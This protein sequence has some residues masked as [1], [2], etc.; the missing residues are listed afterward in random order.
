MAA[1]ESRKARSILRSI[2]SVEALTRGRDAARRSPLLIG[3]I[4]IDNGFPPGIT[5]LLPHDDKLPNRLRHL[6]PFILHRRH[7]GT[8][9]VGE[10]PGT[11]D[12]DLQR[13]IN[14]ISA[15]NFVSA[16]CNS[17]LIP[18]AVE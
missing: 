11:G 2:P 8:P 13:R 4:D 3:I 15:L 14:F 12:F 10:V 7:I 18:V 9:L 6:A 16:F 1:A 5:L 17:A